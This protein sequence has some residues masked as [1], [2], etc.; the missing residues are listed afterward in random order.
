T[1]EGLRKRGRERLLF[2]KFKARWQ[3]LKKSPVREGFDTMIGDIREMITHA[4]DT[5]NLILD[6]DLDSYYLMDVTLLA[7]PQTQF[8]LSE[9]LVEVSDLLKKE[10]WSGDDRTR[11]RVLAALLQES[12]LDRITASIR[13][14]LNEDANFYGVS[15]TLNARISP[16]FEAYA[17]DSRKVVEMLSAMAGGVENSFS[18]ATFETLLLKAI[19]SSFSFWHTGVEEYDILLQTRIKSFLDGRQTALVSTGIALSFAIFLVIGVGLSILSPIRQIQRFSNEVARGNLDAAISEKFSGELEDLSRD[20]QNMVDQMK[21]KMAAEAKTEELKIAMEAVEKA[22]Q[23]AHQVEEFQKNEIIKLQTVLKSLSEGN[24]TQCYQAGEGQ[25]TTIDARNS[26]REIEEAMK[27]AFSNLAKLVTGIQNTSEKLWNSSQEFL[28]VSQELLGRSDDLALQSNAVAGA[29]EEISQSINNMAVTTEQVS[30][31]V[32]TVSSTAEEMSQTMSNVARSVEGLWKS[33]SS[34][35]EN[36]SEASKVASRATSLSQNASETMNILGRAANEIG[37]VTNVIKRIAEQTNLLALNA[38]IEAASAGEAGKGFAVVANEVKELANQSARAAEDIAGK[39]EGIQGNTREAVSVMSEVAKIIS[40]INDSVGI[41][42]SSVEKQNKSANEISM[43]VS[44]T[45]KGANDI[46]LSIADLAKGM[47]DVSRNTADLAK[48]SN[49]LAS[50]IQGVNKSA[51]ACNNGAKQVNSL[52]GQ[53]AGV[54]GDLKR[55][56]GTFVAH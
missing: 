33:I 39:I 56:V 24:L 55:E 4:G 46:A 20:I 9:I 25:T 44:E 45:T 48:A 21:A 38:T 29:T 31:T 10:E 34:I 12:D 54:S 16:V 30:V 8:R 2:P 23:I 17:A 32:S 11:L 51:E 1:E 52:A 15:A 50:N 41:I 28:S 40:N 5:S 19:K 6:P 35:A 14:S 26:F 43:S 49:E 3:D 13:T 37:K 47:N 7:L 53:L 22:R 42:S 18:A 27:T 36:S